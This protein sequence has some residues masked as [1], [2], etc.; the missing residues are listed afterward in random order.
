MVKLMVNRVKECKKVVVFGG[1]FIEIEFADDIWQI[2]SLNVTVIE[3]LDRMLANGHASVC[4]GSTDH[5][6][7]CSSCFRCH[8]GNVNLYHT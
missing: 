3:K 6:S 5:V 2:D 8:T 1:G 4:D 7:R